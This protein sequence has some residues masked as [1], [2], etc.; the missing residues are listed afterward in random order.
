MNISASLFVPLFGKVESTLV[1][2]DSGGARE[3]FINHNSLHI[4]HVFSED[5]RKLF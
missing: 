3:D 1:R 2:P 5:S 4:V